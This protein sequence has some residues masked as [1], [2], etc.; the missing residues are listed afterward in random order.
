[1]LRWCFSAC[2]ACARL[3]DETTGGLERRGRQAKRSE[4]SSVVWD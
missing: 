3:V 4:V 1:M 2:R